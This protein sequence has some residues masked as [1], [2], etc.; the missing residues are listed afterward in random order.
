MTSKR[1]IG[2]WAALG[3]RLLPLLGMAGLLMLTGCGKGAAKLT[4]VE[5]KVTLA[6]KPMPGGTVAF[7]PVDRKITADAPGPIGTIDADGHYKL[8]TA[9]KPGAPMGKYKV[10]IGVPPPEGA[11]G[12]NSDPSAM[13][14][15]PKASTAP[16]IAINQK[17]QSE[18]TTDLTVEVK[19]KGSPGDYDLTLTK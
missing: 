5:G 9:G 11:M 19:D 15:P 7:W 12:A 4:P 18:A 13:K 10:T 17:Y 6:G 14:G 2:Q 1:T 16:P 8:T 3:A